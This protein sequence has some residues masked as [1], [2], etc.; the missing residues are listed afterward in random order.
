MAQNSGRRAGELAGEVD[1]SGA[2]TWL[3]GIP[4]R[5]RV[6][7]R[8]Q[9]GPVDTGVQLLPGAEPLLLLSAPRR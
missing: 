9:P 2:A 8:I 7:A 4:L 6:G 5:E 1:D 3:G